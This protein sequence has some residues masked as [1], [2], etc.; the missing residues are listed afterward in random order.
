MSPDTSASAVARLASGSRTP[1]LVAGVLFLLAGGAA[2]YAANLRNQ[3]EDVELRLVDAVMKM[4][5]SEQQVAV[6]QAQVNAVRTNLT[7]MT[8]PDVIE[9]KLNG[10]GTA[11]D[12]AGRVFI[13][14]TRGVLFAASKMPALPADKT[15]Q[16]W[17]LTK[18]APVS[19]GLVRSDDQGNVTAAYDVPADLTVPTGFAVTMEAEAG[20][21]SPTE[22]MLLTSK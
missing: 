5:V 21:T 3:L 16:L 6:S 22:P 9:L 7:L 20:A 19:A 8:S 1:W 15:Y 14:R 2:V 10:K 4:Q 12:A 18:G 17:Y 13:S 11:A